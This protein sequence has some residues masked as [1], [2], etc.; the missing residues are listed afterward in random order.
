MTQ[1]NRT[2]ETSDSACITAEAI[3]ACE[4]QVHHNMSGNL[5]SISLVTHLHHTNRTSEHYT[6]RTSISG[7]VTYVLLACATPVLPERFEKSN[8]TDCTA[9]NSD[10]ARFAVLAHETATSVL[11]NRSRN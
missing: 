3:L 8:N 11:R 1:H 5:A 10:S 4:T 6:N 9:S 7:I 2:N